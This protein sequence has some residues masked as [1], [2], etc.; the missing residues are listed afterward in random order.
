MDADTPAPL[1]ALR[2]DGGAAANDT[3]M[4][5][6]A[7]LLGVPVQRPATLETTAMGAAFLAGLAV[8]FW[9]GMDEIRQL[10]AGGSVFQPNPDRARANALYA[11]W[12]EALERSK[13]WNAPL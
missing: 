4:Q 11:R 13:R 2:V 10:Q 3:I 12:Q 8:G 5:F 1:R 7:D 6:Q 9:Q